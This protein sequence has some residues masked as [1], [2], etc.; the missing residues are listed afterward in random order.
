MRTGAEQLL[1][2]C[3]RCAEAVVPLKECLAFLAPY[4]TSMTLSI[5]NTTNSKRLQEKANV[6][7]HSICSKVD[8]TKHAEDI[9]QHLL[10]STCAGTCLHVR[11]LV[12][13]HM[14][15]RVGSWVIRIQSYLHSS[16]LVIVVL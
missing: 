11:D 4:L 3:C 12:P 6:Q 8:R 5:S 15:L 2:C 16:F 9:A 10:D 1:H 14:E 13:E 7:D